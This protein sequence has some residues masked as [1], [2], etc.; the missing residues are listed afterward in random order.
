MFRILLLAYRTLKTQ[1]KVMKPKISPGM[2]LYL[3]E[4]RRVSETRVSEKGP[5]DTSRA[6]LAPFLLSP[7]LPRKVSAIRRE[8]DRESS[9]TR[10]V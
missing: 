1:F 6:H 9:R 5:G 3:K 8:R 7:P 2:S 4:S 10:D